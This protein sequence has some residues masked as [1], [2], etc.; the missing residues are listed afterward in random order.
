MLIRLEDVARQQLERQA[1]AA[2]L[3]DPQFDIKVAKSIKPVA[4]CNK[5]VAIEIIDARSPNRI[6]LSASCPGDDGWR[7]DF[8]ARATISAKVAVSAVPLSAGKALGPDDATLERRDITTIPDSISDLQTLS[9]MSSRRTLR[10]GEVLRQSQL[11]AEI[12]IK[13]GETVRIF[14][15]REQIEVSMAGE[16]MDAGAQG[17]VIRVRNGASGTVIRARVTAAGVVEPADLA[18]AAK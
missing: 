9:G 10:A 3:L 2:K 17:A 6:R 4:P 5:K 12:L 14:A 18:P 7:V 15:R 1:D 16:A 8:V 11:A 13:R